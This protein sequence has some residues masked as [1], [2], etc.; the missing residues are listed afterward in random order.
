MANVI[1]F[2]PFCVPTVLLFPP[3]QMSFTPS[4]PDAPKYWLIVAPVAMLLVVSVA[5]AI[6][7]HV[8]TAAPVCR[9][10]Q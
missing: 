3:R 2:P 8:P 4:E 5:T 6:L 9:P 1:L 7:S 10:H